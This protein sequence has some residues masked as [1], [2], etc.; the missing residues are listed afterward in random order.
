[1]FSI[2]TSVTSLLAQMPNGANAQAVLPAQA[3]MRIFRPVLS[4]HADLQAVERFEKWVV[5]RDMNVSLEQVAYLW[6][7][8]ES[9]FLK[10][11]PKR[12]TQWLNDRKL[13]SPYQL[14]VEFSQMI[15]LRRWNPLVLRK[16][17]SAIGRIQI[18]TLE[19]L[20]YSAA[21]IVFFGCALA[22]WSLLGSLREPLMIGFA[23]LGFA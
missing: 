9:F 6:V 16:S 17:G 15:C 10:E 1:M 18:K 8:Y 13:Q 11:F 23:L 7:H 21:F 2:N 3:A 20:G 4:Q 12:I 5:S 22:G 19:A 14:G